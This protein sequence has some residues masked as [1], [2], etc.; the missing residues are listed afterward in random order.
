MFKVERYDAYHPAL[1]SRVLTAG[2]YIENWED[3]CPDD[4]LVIYDSD[5]DG[6]IDDADNDGVTDLHDLCANYDDRVD[7]DN[8][9]I[10]DGW[11]I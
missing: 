4:Q 9:M 11:T 5:G 6:C 1:K 10:P 2:E 7:L 3:Q 8:D